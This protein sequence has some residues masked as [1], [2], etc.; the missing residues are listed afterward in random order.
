M[1]H[2]NVDA[3]PAPRSLRPVGVAAAIALAVLAVMAIGLYVMMM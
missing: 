3:R 2:A 1:G